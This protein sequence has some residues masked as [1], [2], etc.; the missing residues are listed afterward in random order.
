MLYSNNYLADTF[1]LVQSLII[2]THGEAVSMNLDLSIKYPTHYTYEEY[3]IETWKH[4]INMTGEYHAI[5]KMLYTDGLILYVEELGREEVL[6]KELLETLPTLRDRL[7]LFDTLYTDLVDKYPECEVLIRGIILP[8][9]MD[10]IKDNPDGTI[11][12][13][14]DKLV[15]NSETNLML[16]LN[17][18]SIAFNKRW[19]IAEYIITD[20]LYAADYLVKL[21]TALITKCLNVRLSNIG[22]YKVH[23]FYMN[24]FFKSNLDVYKHSM[25]FSDEVKLYLY[26]NMKYMIKHTGKE[27]VLDMLVKN[28]LERS[29]ITVEEVV[30]KQ[31]KV[32]IL[33]D[34][35]VKNRESLYIVPY[36]VFNGTGVKISNSDT[37][38]LEIS[39]GNYKDY[40]RRLQ[41]DT[42][43]GTNKTTIERSKVLV[44]DYNGATRTHPYNEPMIVFENWIY[45][46]FVKD[47]NTNLLYTDQTNLTY[48]L[49]EKTAVYLVLKYLFKLSGF[50]ES[51][52][53]NIILSKIPKDEFVTDNLISNTSVA[54]D[55]Q[56][57]LDSINLDYIDLNNTCNEVLKLNELLWTYMNDSYNP[58]LRS[59]GNLIFNRIH[60]PVKIELS[61]EEVLIDDLFVD[62]V[63]YSNSYDYRKAIVSIIE[64]FS[65]INID[66]RTFIDDLLKD[67]KYL[68]NELTSYTTQVIPINNYPVSYVTNSFSG[69]IVGPNLY[70]IDK[71]MFVHTEPAIYQLT[72]EARDINNDLREILLGI[73]SI[74]QADRYDYRLHM[75]GTKEPITEVLMNTT[76]TITYE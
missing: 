25:Q 27:H 22:T 51:T 35:P 67:F 32:E 28:V 43:V 31:Q 69:K 33:D 5:D 58:A 14:N 60:E 6:T 46:V 24:E 73:G 42:I 64:L 56:N 75:S 15:E 57:Y 4:Y 49:N 40:A 63:T 18:F 19:F 48:T 30:K 53:K 29:N 47:I 36:G 11:V 20:E 65:G 41:F 45:R 2:L 59:D 74:T 34:T 50:T 7:L 70:K 21:Y 68:T 10:E 52:F 9:T 39:E 38:A 1:K 62:P 17:K 76:V 71:A 55:I 54:D 44:L 72:L 12:N 3:D 61:D 13:F 8:V 66:K 26:R 16:E 37:Y 23:S